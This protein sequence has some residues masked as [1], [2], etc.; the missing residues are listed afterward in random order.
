MRGTEMY[1]D[2]VLQS[3]AFFAFQLTA[4]I[5]FLKEDYYV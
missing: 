5:G 4:H 2:F 3:K 1:T